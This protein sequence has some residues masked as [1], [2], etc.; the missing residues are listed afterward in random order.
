MRKFSARWGV[1]VQAILTL[2]IIMRPVCADQG[3]LVTG[4]DADGKNV[5]LVDFDTKL[6]KRGDHQHSITIQDAQKHLGR[7]PEVGDILVG[8][9]EGDNKEFKTFAAPVDPGPRALALVGAAILVVLVAALVTNF[10]PQ[11]FLIAMDNRYSNSQCQVALW[12]GAAMTAYLALVFL[13]LN[14]GGAAFAGGVAITTN[15]LIMSGLSALTFGGA[16]VITATKTGGASP[17]PSLPGAGAAPAPAPAPPAQ[18]QVGGLAVA[19]PPAVPKTLAPK[20]NLLTDLVQNDKN[21]P[22]FGDF[23]M[24][25]ISLIAVV[26]YLLSTFNSLGSIPLQAHVSLPDIDTSLLGGFGVGQGAYLIKKAAL[27]VGRG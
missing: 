13:R 2:L 22:D 16:K 8:T 23:Q 15:L 19:G 4:V 18:V 7:T 9:V 12:F 21:E 20:P 10:R 24:I 26:I 14:A 3:F 25:F 11:R 6:F 5:A 17:V 27:P 1:L